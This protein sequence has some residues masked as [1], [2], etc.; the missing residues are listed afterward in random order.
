MRKHCVC[1][2]IVGKWHATACEHED[3][4][5]RRF[6]APCAIAW[7][8]LLFVPFISCHASYYL[9]PSAPT[10]C[11]C[12][13]DIRRCRSILFSLFAN[14][15]FQ[16]KVICI[17]MCVPVFFQWRDGCRLRR[18]IHSQYEPTRDRIKLKFHELEKKDGTNQIVSW[19]Y[20]QLFLEKFL[21]ICR[22]FIVVYVVALVVGHMH[23]NV[24][25]GK[26][27][28]QSCTSK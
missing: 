12:C 13:I 10:I 20:L 16:E 24:R 11:T 21:I 27:N 4:S 8:K 5:V 15:S 3:E 9:S 7:V 19:H 18:I 28:V 26:W 2:P 25:P 17:F 22:S 1:L 6:F 23:W 14:V